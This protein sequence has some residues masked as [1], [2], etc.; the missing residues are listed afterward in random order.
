MTFQ[1]I[2]AFSGVHSVWS[3]QCC[4][5]GAGCSTD[6]LWVDLLGHFLDDAKVDEQQHEH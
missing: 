6:Q 1:R 5:N 3:D 2:S 4:K